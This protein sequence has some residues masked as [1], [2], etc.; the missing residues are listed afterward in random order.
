MLLKKL[1]TNGIVGKNLKWFK[2]YLNNRKQYI[3]INNEEKANLLLV[4][5]G[6]L[7]GSILEPFPFLIYIND[8]QFV[9]DVFADDANLFYSHKDINTLFLKV[10]NKLH[11]INQ[12]FISNKLSLNTK[13]QNIHFSINEVNKMIFSF[14]FLNRK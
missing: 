7:Q 10:N 4:K 11:K 3:Q 8:L 13:N 6:V 9:S 14:Y 1:E 12:W 2:N 5:C